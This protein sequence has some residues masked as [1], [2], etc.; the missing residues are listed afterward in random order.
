MENV[1]DIIYRKL[2]ELELT[3]VEFAKQL[4][5]SRSSLNGYLHNERQ[6]P[7]DLLVKMSKKLQLS[8]DYIYH[9]QPSIDER[10]MSEREY[11][12]INEYRKLEENKQV[13]AHD[14]FI[15]ILKICNQE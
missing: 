5:I 14:A 11:E 8:L 7:F 12:I 9:L 1:G 10:T 4:N 2:E 3:Q 13:Q 6:I 15:K